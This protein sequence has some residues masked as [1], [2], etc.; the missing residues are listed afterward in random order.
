MS[1]EIH[2]R[3][4]IITILYLVIASIFLIS[5]L[6]EDEPDDNRGSIIDNEIGATIYLVDGESPAGGAKVRIY[7]VGFDPDSDGLSKITASNQY[8]QTITNEE[9]RFV[10]TDSL[11]SG[12]YNILAELGDHKSYQDSIF[13]SST[14][15]NIQ[16][17][18]LRD[19]GQVSGYVKMQPGTPLNSVVISVLGS[20][21]INRNVNSNGFFTLPPMAPGTYSVAFTT[22]QDEYVTTFH[23]ITVNSG[24]HDTIQEPFEIIYTGIPVL[25][26]LSI[27]YDTLNGI[28]QLSW[29]P[30]TYENYQEYAVFKDEFDAA[31]KTETPFKATSDTFFIDSIFNK[32]SPTHNFSFNDSND[33]H[34]KYRVA[35]RSNTE[36]LGNTYKYADVLAVSPMKLQPSF[37][38]TI[39][40]ATK[41]Q[42]VYGTSINDT[43]RFC[44]RVHNN[45]RELSKITWK[46]FDKQI[47]INQYEFDAPTKIVNETFKYSWAEVGKKALEI[48]VE[49]AGGAKWYDTLSNVTIV[50]YTPSL[51]PQND[52]LV[53][54]TDTVKLIV[55]ASATNPDGTIKKYY[56]DKGADGW[57]DSTDT[58]EYNFYSANCGELP[59]VWGARNDD[60]VFRADTFSIIFNC[61]PSNPELISLNNSHWL[62]YN[63]ADGNGTLPLTFK[64]SNPEGIMDTLTYTLFI[65]LTSKTLNLRYSGKDPHFYL[66]DVDTNSTFFWKLLV[67]DLYDD[68]TEK[69]GFFSAP[70]LPPYLCYKGNF[71][72]I[73]DSVMYS[74]VVI[75]KQAWMAENLKHLPAR[76]GRI[77]Y[78]NLQSRCD[79]LGGLYSW[80]GARET[81]NGSINDICPNGWHLPTLTE[82]ETLK[83]VIEGADKGVK[84]KSKDFWNG[85]DDYGFSAL[86]AGNYSSSGHFQDLGTQTIFWTSTPKYN[87]VAWYV[88]L[89]SFSNDLLQGG[90]QTTTMNSVRCIED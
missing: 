23:S 43:L 13:I 51:I 7:S 83:E 78:G 11:E 37:D 27:A 67:K 75:G 64:V 52:M 26:G 88:R 66:E 76:G 90:L 12:E 50:K 44:L 22:N 49:D 9:G 56:W 85:T 29:D 24:I 10:I 40:H 3:K 8:F 14:M 46:D 6:V 60:G 1:K 54:G 38:I 74:C 53:S 18:T 33:Y 55:S 30:T 70:P 28:V 80:E 81:T 48:I 77:C 61:P 45:Y 20:Q 42:E 87:N 21:Y 34:Y 39:K 69:S 68:S 15:N 89:N 19:P 31:N 73:R 16:D 25:T 62:D 36:D 79:S 58:P 41:N 17:D 47:E 57:D 72:D 65:G 59:I 82:W 71:K 5:C 2:I 63:K 4:I 86:P 84:L 32:N 35:I